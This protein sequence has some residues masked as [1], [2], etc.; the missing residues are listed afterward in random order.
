MVKV[1]IK[2][3]RTSVVRNH[4]FRNHQLRHILC[5]ISVCLLDCKVFDESLERNLKLKQSKKGFSFLAAT[6][7]S[8]PSP[9]S[10]LHDLLHQLVSLLQNSSIN[11]LDF[12]QP[13]TASNMPTDQTGYVVSSSHVADAVL[14]GQPSSTLPQ[15][16]VLPLPNNTRPE[17][18]RSVP[19]VLSLVHQSPFEKV[20]QQDSLVHINQAFTTIIRPILNPK[21]FSSSEPSVSPP[22]PS[23]KPSYKDVV[24]NHQ[25]A[26]NILPSPPN[27]PTRKGTK[28]TLG[29]KCEENGA[30]RNNFGTRLQVHSRRSQVTDYPPG[31]NAMS[32]QKNQVADQISERDA[33]R[34]CEFILADINS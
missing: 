12:G 10:S 30:E 31:G 4:Q 11:S 7:A 33:R 18:A 8:S 23:T 24:G 5:T 29:E 32:A 6:A 22:I 2:Q 13:K 14:I 17:I 28:L 34:R 9:G 21:G 16:I 15:G 1:S 27:L 3:V 19:F 20:Q 25:V 26:S